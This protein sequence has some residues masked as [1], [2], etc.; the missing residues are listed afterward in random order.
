MAFKFGFTRKEMRGA[1][2]VYTGEHIDHFY[3]EA[4]GK[5]DTEQTYEGFVERNNY[6][7]RI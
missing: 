7:D 1:D 3:G 2:D 6:L 5:D 4:V